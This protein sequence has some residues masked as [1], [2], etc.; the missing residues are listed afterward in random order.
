MRLSV[1]LSAFAL[2]D[3]N[4]CTNSGKILLELIRAQKKSKIRGCL[5]TWLNEKLN[6]FLVLAWRYSGKGCDYITSKK[7]LPKRK[8]LPE[9]LKHFFNENR[10][11]FGDVYDMITKERLDTEKTRLPIQLRSPVDFISQFL[12]RRI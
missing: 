8:S 5:V 3:S 7:F 11:F 9:S 4:P 1:F 2:V 10:S 12:K 6:L